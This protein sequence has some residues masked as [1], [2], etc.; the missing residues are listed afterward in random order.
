ME[1]PRCVGETPGWGE[2]SRPCPH[3]QQSARPG[4]LPLKGGHTPHSLSGDVTPHVPLW[5]R[6]HTRAPK[7]E[8]LLRG[9]VTPRFLLGGRSH[10][11]SPSGEVTPRVPLGEGISRVHLRGRSQLRSL[12]GVRSHPRSLSGMSQPRSLSG[13][14][15]TPHPPSLREDV[16]PGHC[17][18]TLRDCGPS[19]DSC[20]RPVTATLGTQKHGGEG[21]PGEAFR[22]HLTFRCGES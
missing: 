22:A 4:Q 13:E 7:P 1:N 19:V 21:R 8:V 16:T 18:V 3:R 11:R 5:G 12:S 6:S 14:G 15:R 9:K 20:L 17:A 10:P 2:T